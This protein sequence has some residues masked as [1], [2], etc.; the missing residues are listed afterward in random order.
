MQEGIA[1]F[2]EVITMFCSEK[3]EILFITCLLTYPKKFQFIMKKKKNSGFG[4]GIHLIYLA[5]LMN[6]IED[7]F[8]SVKRFIKLYDDR[9]IS[10]I[11]I[12]GEKIFNSV[13]HF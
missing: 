6:I 1:L 4:V 7:K 13:F 9:N 3:Y 11:K 12:L 5:K 10:E 8:Y 2:L